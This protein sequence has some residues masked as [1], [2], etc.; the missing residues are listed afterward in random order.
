MGSRGF[1]L[2]FDI[3]WYD[4]LM[5]HFVRLPFKAIKYKYRKTTDFKV[6]LP[7]CFPKIFLFFKC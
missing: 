6:T 7:K 4:W 1:T 3:A 5:T 2:C